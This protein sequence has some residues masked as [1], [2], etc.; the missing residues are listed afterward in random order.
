[1]RAFGVRNP[2]KW[3]AS[4]LNINILLLRTQFSRSVTQS[5]HTLDIRSHSLPICL[6]QY[7]TFYIEVGDETTCKEQK[8]CKKNHSLIAKAAKPFHIKSFKQYHSPVI[9]QKENKETQEIYW[10]WFIRQSFH[11]I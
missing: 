9:T 1:M 2:K 10:R 5:K 11:L 4:N 8:C 7:Y 6:T 3:E